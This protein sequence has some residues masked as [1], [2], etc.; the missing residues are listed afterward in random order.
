MRSTSLLS[1]LIAGALLTGCANLPPSLTG[2]YH[3]SADVY[4]PGQAQ[5]VQNVRLGVVL[6]VRPVIIAAKQTQTAGGSAIGA[7]L[8]GLLGHQVG[9]GNGRTIAT[10][11]GALGGAVAGNL[12]GQHAYQQPG[13]EISVKLDDGHV[14]S[15][16]QAADVTL[17]VG[18]RV[19]LISGAYYGE[20]SRVIPLEAAP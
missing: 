14:V 4:T 12:T 3:N 5:Q 7:V 11:A 10:V 2:E 19:Q 15:L 13:L 1:G 16:T 20:S 8:G 9:D 6:S 17:T 18:E